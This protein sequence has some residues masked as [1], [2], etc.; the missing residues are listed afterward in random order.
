[1]QWNG[2]ETKATKDD[3]KSLG[4]VDGTGED[5]HGRRGEFI[6]EVEEV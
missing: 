1:V 4:I 5:D 2:W 6:D 3:G